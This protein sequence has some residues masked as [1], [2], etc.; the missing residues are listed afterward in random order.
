MKRFIRKKDSV[1][2]VKVR[3]DDYLLLFSN[4]KN[5]TDFE[6]GAPGKMKSLLKNAET[7]VFLPSLVVLK[8]ETARMSLDTITQN[9]SF[10]IIK[11]HDS[12]EYFLYKG[13]E[14]LDSFK[15]KDDDLSDILE[16]CLHKILKKKWAILEGKKEETL[17]VPHVMAPDAVE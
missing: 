9:G 14:R 7:V 16:E 2:K 1:K 13:E 10:Y 15:I 5:S 4:Q 6:S 12:I 11:D 8:N 17:I 3:K